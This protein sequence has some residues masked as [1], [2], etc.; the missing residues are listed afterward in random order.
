M[1]CGLFWAVS[2]TTMVAVR[3]PFAAGLSVTVMTQLPLGARDAGQA[4]VSEK[5][6]GSAPA[7]V[8]P[9]I[10]RAVPP[11]LLRVMVLV[12]LAELGLAVPQLSLL[13]LNDAT[14]SM[15]VAETGTIW[16]PPGALSL[17]F[18]S[19]ICGV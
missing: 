7:K 13:A 12:T 19:A 16:E 15:T 11:G 18:R 6:W 3:E 2:V 8:K 17:I 14:G 5:S 9:V 10:P 1:D 4:L